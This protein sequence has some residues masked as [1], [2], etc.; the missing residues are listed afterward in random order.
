MAG[1]QLAQS[2]FSLERGGVWATLL[3]APHLLKEQEFED[4]LVR[5]VTGFLKAR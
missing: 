2:G 5:L 4:Q 3:D 1:I